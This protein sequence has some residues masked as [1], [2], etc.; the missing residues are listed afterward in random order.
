MGKFFVF[1][2]AVQ[3]QMWLLVVIAAVNSVVAAF[4]YL[5]IVRYMFFVPEEGEAERAKVGAP[6]QVVLGVTAALT[7]LLGVIPGPL[8]AWA[9][10]STRALLLALR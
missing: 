9:S 6:L 10:E 1:G 4:Y 5:N 2:A 7:L 3:G 8:Y